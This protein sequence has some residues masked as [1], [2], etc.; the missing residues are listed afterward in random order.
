MFNTTGSEVTLTTVDFKGMYDLCTG[1]VI[2]ER[3]VTLLN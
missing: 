2:Q 3:N 1:Q